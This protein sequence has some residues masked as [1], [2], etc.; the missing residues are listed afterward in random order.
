[1]SE[2][3][4]EVDTETVID[5]R[6]YT[7]LLKMYIESTTGLKPQSGN[8]NNHIKLEISSQMESSHKEGYIL[9]IDDSGIGIRSGYEEGLFYGLQTFRQILFIYGRSLPFCKIED[10]PR[11]EYRGFM[12]D[13]CRHFFEVDMVLKMLD[14]CALLKLNTFHFHITEDQGWRVEIEKYPLLTKIGSFRKETF[15]RGKSDNTPVQGFYTKEDIKKIAAYSE[16]LNIKIIPEFD[17]PGHFR[18]AIAAYPHLSCEEKQIEVDTRYGIS[19]HIACAG[20]ESTYVFIKDVL[21]ELI[22]MFNTDMIHIGGDE[23][24][25]GKWKQ[26]PHCQEKIKKEGLS[27]E[28]DLQGFFINYIHRYLKEKNIKTIT[29]NESLKASNLDKEIIIQHWLDGFKRKN[30]IKGIN[31]GRRTILSDFFHFYLDHPYAAVPLRKTYRFNPLLKGIKKGNEKYIMGLEAPL[32]TEYVSDERRVH[33]MTFPRLA[34][35]SERAWSKHQ[36]QD[37]SDFLNRLESFN[38][39]LQSMQVDFPALHQADVKGIKR[40]IQILQLIVRRQ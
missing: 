9:D 38:K 36:V 11:F 13:T 39:I 37:Y 2:G 16:K 12:L 17:L 25:K 26:C 34:A 1:M 24:P 18:S 40:F 27:G 20:K 31:D 6:F 10:F 35:L 7:D 3:H 21:D 8:G 4:F 30:V 23:A 5:S 32:W 29:W 14:L 28:E 19:K 33:Y 22:D 15:I